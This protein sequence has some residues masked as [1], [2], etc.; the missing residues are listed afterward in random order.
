MVPEGQTI[1]QSK[2]GL[3]QDQQVIHLVQSKL[4]EG[5][6][7]SKQGVEKAEVEMA[8]SHLRKTPEGEEVCFLYSKLTPVYFFSRS[9]R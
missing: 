9:F 8:I 1:P 7:L 5:I 6:K 4:D 2:L 3:N